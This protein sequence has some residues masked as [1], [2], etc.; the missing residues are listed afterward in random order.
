MSGK[1]PRRASASVRTDDDHEHQPGSS[2]RDAMRA[3]LLASAKPEY[4][5]L[6]FRGQKVEVRQP[7]VESVLNQSKVDE[8]GRKVGPIEML[9]QCLYIP[10]TNERI[11][12]D[13]DRDVLLN[14]P[15][16]EDLTDIFNAL[17][18]LGKANFPERKR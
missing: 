8:E 1:T 6:P 11:F 4:K 10:G 13:T 15:F 7:S 16:T 18:S 3:A 17:T 5:I 2:P 14:M 9:I 12:E